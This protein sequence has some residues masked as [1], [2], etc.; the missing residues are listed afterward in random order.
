ME[1]VGVAGVVAQ[2]ARDFGQ[3]FGEGDGV[4]FSIVPGFDCGESGRVGVD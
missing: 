1:L 3:V 2:G 4:G